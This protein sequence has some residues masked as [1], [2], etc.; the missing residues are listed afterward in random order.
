MQGILTAAANTTEQKQVVFKRWRT[1]QIHAQAN[2]HGKLIMTVNKKS[3]H[4]CSFSSGSRNIFL[5]PDVE[6]PRPQPE[7]GR[8]EQ[9]S[10]TS[11]VVR[12]LSAS[13]LTT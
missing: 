4:F 5:W 10:F 9:F 8:V 3:G 2:F 1:I 7:N 6:L 13:F 11:R 12:L